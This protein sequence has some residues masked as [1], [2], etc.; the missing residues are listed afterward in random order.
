M[1]RL[2][3]T[4][5]EARLLAELLADN[6]VATTSWASRVHK[7]GTWPGSS[8]LQ[9]KGSKHPTVWV[10]GYQTIA[11]EG[12]TI[13]GGEIFVEVDLESQSASFRDLLG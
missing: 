8:S 3:H 9:G 11:P 6:L 1:A 4:L 12:T 13:D 10:V 7:V 2:R 5:E